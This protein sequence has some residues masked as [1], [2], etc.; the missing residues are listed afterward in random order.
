MN[1]N[2]NH[3]VHTSLD[4][5]NWR[6]SVFR[7]KSNNCCAHCLRANRASSSHLWT[8]L[9]SPAIWYGQWFN[10]MSLI[11]MSKAPPWSDCVLP[12]FPDNLLAPMCFS[13][14][15]V[16][17]SHKWRS[18]LLVF[19]WYEVSSTSY[20]VNCWFRLDPLPCPWYC[21]LLFLCAVVVAGLDRAGGL[22]RSASLS[23]ARGRNFWRIFKMK[24]T[25]LESLRSWDW[26]RT[27][28]ISSRMISSLDETSAQSFSCFLIVS[29]TT[30]L[31]VISRNGTEHWAAA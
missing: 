5:F 21:P 13:P 4:W 1:S 22:G 17:S 31:L 27:Q 14:S 16:W 6:P 12:V 20:S 10:R 30:E 15:S 18:I 11:D 3:E 23:V 29:R 28:R 2:D 26:V 24:W 25:K 9:R 8:L 19:K 7:K